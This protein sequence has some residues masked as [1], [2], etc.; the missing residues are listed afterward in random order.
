MSPTRLAGIGTLATTAVLLALFLLHGQPTGAADPGAMEA[1]SIDTDIT[2]NTA[3]SL[4]PWDECIIASPGD[5]ITLDVTATNIPAG[6]PMIAFAFTL[7]SSA[8]VVTVVST[9][10]NFL[11]ASTPGSSLL[12]V[13]DPVPDA[14]GIWH[15][16]VV[17]LSAS[18]IVPAESGSGALHRITVRVASDAPA[19][20]YPLGLAEAY[21]DDT[22]DSWYP[23]Q[24]STTPSSP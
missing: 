21:H 19:G 1:M 5:T 12:D 22:T 9:D 14:D 16:A 3:T 17:D 20:V 24:P 2:G 18:T 11:L 13:S 15:A 4:G 8:G 6:Y 7:N 10:P 23:L